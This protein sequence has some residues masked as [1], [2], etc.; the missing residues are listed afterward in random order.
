VGGQKVH[1][2]GRGLQAILF[3]AGN[4]LIYYQGNLLEAF[5]ESDGALVNTL[6]AAGL[7][8]D[9]NAFLAQ[10]RLR[11]EQYYA[12]RETEFIEYTTA[13]ILRTSLAEWGY[14]NI[15]ETL[16]RKAL[17]DMYAV[18][19]V[20]WQPED[21]AIPTLEALRHQ[22]YRLGMISNAA[23][24]ADVQVLIDK[25]GLRPYLEIILTS[26]AV[27]IR[28][29]NPRI[30]QAALDFW[31]IRSHEAVMVGD[32]LGADILGAKNAGIYAI[33]ITRRA[34]TPA[35]LAHQFT[36]QPDATVNTLSE[37]PGLLEIL[38]AKRSNSG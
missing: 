11:L 14:T 21:D 31:G 6:L 9:E 1:S 13:Y 3:D 22:G 5:A 19:Q 32:T 18:T 38:S 24:D 28:K 17:A 7:K 37:L 16:L 35:N 20:H 23:D 2:P 34:N 15:P 25:A 27:G 33:W 29:P 10:F 36:I 8:L 4:T 30:F 12:E 26:A